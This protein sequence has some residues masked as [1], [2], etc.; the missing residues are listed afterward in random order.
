MVAPRGLYA[1]HPHTSNI[2]PLAQVIFFGQQ[3]SEASEAHS[4]ISALDLI[5]VHSDLA[6]LGTNIGVLR[7]QKSRID[8]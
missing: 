3:I 1:N 6:N 4:R 7:T 2:A 5:A 8:R